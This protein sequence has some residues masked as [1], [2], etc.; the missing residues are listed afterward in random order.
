MAS[1]VCVEASRTKSPLAAAR[2]LRCLT[3]EKQRERDLYQCFIK[4]RRSTENERK[5]GIPVHCDPELPW[6][7]VMSDVFTEIM[8]AGRDAFN[9]DLVEQ[10]GGALA[11]H[12]YAIVDRALVRIHDV[13]LPK[14]MPLQPLVP[15]RLNS[16]ANDMPGLV[17]LDPEAPYF[18]ELCAS[19]ALAED[20]PRENILSCLLKIDKGITQYALARHLT[21]ILIRYSPQGQ[22][23][24]RYFDPRVFAHL[25]RILDLEQ[26]LALFGPVK[27][28]TLRFQNGWA[29]IE[30]PALENILSASLHA[31]AEQRERLD[32]IGPINDALERWR[33][34]LKQPWRDLEE[35]RQAAVQAERAIFTAKNQYA[36]SHPD[37]LSAFALDSLA[38]GE[39]F[40]THPRIQS[41]LEDAKNPDGNPYHIA[42][43]FIK[44]D[45][46][47]VIAA[48][49]K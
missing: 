30:R 11:A 6:V 16:E 44:P 15:V 2:A 5:I 34:Q 41:M 25:E 13:G 20:D 21:K 18:V 31:D 40:Y 9:K 26:Y 49:T 23:R 4:K 38:H 24:F 33:Y 8:T 47:A 35:F 29:S 17:P 45:E 46:W 32:I 39:R 28:W 37:D 22:S 10:Y 7:R 1:R 14:N 42:S 27:T 48:E 19:L 43:R 3:R 36:L 12:D